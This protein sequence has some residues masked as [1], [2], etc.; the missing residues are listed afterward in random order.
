MQALLAVDFG[1]VSKFPPNRLCPTV[2]Q[3]LNYIHWIE[4]LLAL[5]PSQSESKSDLIRGCDIG[6]GAS[7]IY[8]LLSIAMHRSSWSFVATEIDHES[9]TAAQHNVEL[10]KWEVSFA[11]TVCRHLFSVIGKRA[12][13]QMQCTQ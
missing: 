12:L 13:H 9:Y 5:S 6:T 4:D 11:S 8:P 2:P 7:C 10:N 3:K 1:V